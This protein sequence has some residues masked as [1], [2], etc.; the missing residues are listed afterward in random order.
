M[1]QQPTVTTTQA[2]APRSRSAARALLDLRRCLAALGLGAA[3]LLGALLDPAAARAA[4]SPGHAGGPAATPVRRPRYA[5]CYRD[6]ATRPSGSVTSP[7][8]SPPRRPRYG[9]C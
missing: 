8:S 5:L 1:N 9:L 6:R 7:A 2:R 4:T 3:L